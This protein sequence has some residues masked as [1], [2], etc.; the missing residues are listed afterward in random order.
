M[1]SVL[2]ISLFTV[3]NLYACDYFNNFMRRFNVINGS[4]EEE[5]L[6]MEPHPQ[7][8]QRFYAW[9]NDWQHD[10]IYASAFRYLDTLV[11]PKFAK[12][13]GYY[14]DANGTITT[15]SVGPVAWWKNLKYDLINPSPSGEYQLYLFGQNSLNE[16]LGYTSGRYTGFCFTFWN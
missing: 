1:E 3:T 6:I 14:V 16:E 8:F 15:K 7:N 2:R 5:W 4:Y 10:K 13:A 12:F 9:C 11:V